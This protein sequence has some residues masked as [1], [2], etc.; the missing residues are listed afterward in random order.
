MGTCSRA[1][2]DRTV[3]PARRASYRR[4]WPGRVI[5]RENIGD[6][7]VYLRPLDPELSEERLYAVPTYAPFGLKSA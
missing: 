2:R 1:A 5:T 4:V 6:K 7:F 3:C